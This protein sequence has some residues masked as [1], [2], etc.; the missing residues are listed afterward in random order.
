LYETRV[1][2]YLGIAFPSTLIFRT[3]RLT[4]A[5]E[6]SF[7]FIRDAHTIQEDENTLVVIAPMRP[8]CENIIFWW[9]A[10]GRINEPLQTRRSASRCLA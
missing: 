3:D 9:S 7:R 2:L 4:E 5:I 6:T 1:A 8:S 10:I